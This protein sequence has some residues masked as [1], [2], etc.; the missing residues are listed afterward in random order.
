MKQ[1][2]RILMC[3]AVAWGLFLAGPRAAGQGPIVGGI[4][5][6]IEAH[7]GFEYI[8]MQVPSASSVPMY[9][10]DSGLTVGVTRHLGIR[11]DLGYARASNVYD[12]GHHS[13]VLTYMAG[14][15]LYPVRTRKASPYVELLLGGARV[16]G[17]IPDGEGGFY[18]GYANDVAWAGGGGMEIRTTPEFAVRVGADYLHTKYFDSNGLLGGQGNLRG[19]VSF[20]YY[21]GG[22][23]R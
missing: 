22:R 9:G 4:G 10:A 21:L 13:D 12:T 11:L 2:S 14:P 3:G 6:E 23:R 18:R 19:V 1:L 15:V 5:P 17:P 7:G 8:G 20:T 16:T